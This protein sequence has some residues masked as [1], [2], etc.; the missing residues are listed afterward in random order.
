MLVG[1][2]VAKFDIVSMENAKGISN[3]VVNA[4]LPCLTFNKIVS[5][6][7][8]RDIKEIGVIILSAF[9]LFVLGATGALFTTFA[10]TV[11]KKFFW[12]SYL[13]VSFQIYQIY[14]LPIFRAWV[15]APFFTAEEADKGVAYSCIFLFIQSF[16][17]MNFGMWRVVG[18]DFRDTKGPDS[19]NITPSVSP[20][21][22]DRKLTEITK[23]PNITRPTNAYQSE[24]ARSNSDLSCNLL[25]QMK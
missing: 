21:N 7:S 2:L 8:W 6:I 25:L 1:Y 23:L 11:P 9:I 20:A 16:L 24:D 15:T 14:L 22:D 5:N 18:L 19:E 4:I 17:M 10:T 12:G 3:M 13:R